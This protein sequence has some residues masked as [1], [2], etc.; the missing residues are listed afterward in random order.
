M[1]GSARRGSSVRL[2]AAVAAALAL[3]PVLVVASVAGVL[4]QRHELTAATVLVAEDQA[5]SVADGLGG[6]DAVALPEST[7][8]GE[9]SLVQLVGGDGTVLDAAGDLRGSDPLM[10]LPPGRATA[11]AT[12]A[13]AISGEDD[14]VVAVAARLP[15]GDSYVVVAR[16]LESVDTAAT[17]TA[18]LLAL[19]S[20][21]VVLVV[22]ALTWYLTGRALRPVDT[23][24]ARVADITGT[25]L[26][27]RV[28]DPGTGDEIARL[29]ATM[30]DM[31]DRLEHSS[32]AQR[33]FVA[34]ASHE[35]RSPIATIR[36]LQETAALS[37][38]PDGPEGLAREVL[39]ETTRLEHLVA[40]LLL[41]ARS[42][43]AAGLPH[44]LVDLT[45]LVAEEANRSRSLP[46]MLDADTPVRVTGD[47]G[48]LARL[49]R[50]LLDN[51]ERHARSRIEVAVT[52][53][54][55]RVD[56]AVS[57]DGPGVAPADRERI[58][59]RFVRLDDARARD[60]G[61]SGLGLSIARQTAVEHGGTLVLVDRP[62]GGSRFVLSLPAHA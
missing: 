47:A 10:T 41:L 43:A 24:R 53:H 50:N 40:D 58:F 1:N 35:L 21:L 56:V 18:Q 31:L 11:E 62:N 14:R 13:N 46:V 30:N 12:V 7:L 36:T 45:P 26:S 38:H 2:R 57:D 55:D 52:P 8:N 49:V 61:G 23:M 34:D 33:R 42:D 16:S 29:A 4:V 6:T 3:A 27:A 37:P 60:D 20:V 54:G 22:T 19:G 59:E 39:A 25:R 51:A 5:R 44:E 15:G 9:E 32:V 48:A 28:P 17:S